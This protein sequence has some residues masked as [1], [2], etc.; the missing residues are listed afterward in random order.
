MVNMKKILYSPGYGAG[1]S[2]WHSGPKEE[3]QFMLEYQPFID[4]VENG[5]EI[6][7]VLQEQF[8]KDWEAAFPGVRSPYMGGIGQLK[9]KDV[10]SPFLIEEYDGYESVMF[11][12]KQDWFY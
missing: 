8:L 5:K 11:A 10:D 3:K 7:E 4:A 1:W 2:T 9:I 12:D 6:D